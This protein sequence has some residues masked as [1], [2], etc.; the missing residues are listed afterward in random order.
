[1]NTLL[2]TFLWDKLSQRAA[3][4]RDETNSK[5]IPDKDKAHLF[6]SSLTIASDMHR[7]VANKFR[8]QLNKLIQHPADVSYQNISE[9]TL[10][11]EEWFVSKMEKQ[12]IEPLEN[13]IS[14]LENQK[15]NKEVHSRA[16][17]IINRF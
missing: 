3:A 2:N 10:K 9:R 11:A 15:K 16:S 12:I 6:L 7:E 14:S 8:N 5:S 17:D 13:H 4:L 1:M